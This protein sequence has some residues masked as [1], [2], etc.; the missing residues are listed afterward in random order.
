MDGWEQHFCPLCILENIY[1]S[2][3]P[4]SNWQ[5]FFVWTKCHRRLP[6]AAAPCSHLPSLLVT[7]SYLSLSII[8][9]PSPWPNPSRLCSGSFSL[10][11]GATL[12]DGMTNDFSLASLHTHQTRRRSKRSKYSGDLNMQTLQT[13]MMNMWTHSRS[14]TDKHAHIMDDNGSF[15]R[16]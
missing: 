14:S 4:S 16:L 13:N 15:Q 7:D 3:F 1:F 12:S 2:H 11:L 10:V 9:S 8:S 6:Q 5:S